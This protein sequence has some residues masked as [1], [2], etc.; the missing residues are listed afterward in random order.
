MGPSRRT[1]ASSEGRHL[2]P[3]APAPPPISHWARFKQAS[4]EPLLLTNGRWLLR[5]RAAWGGAGSGVVLHLVLGE[6][7]R[8][9]SSCRI[10]APVTK[11]AT[12]P[13]PLGPPPQGAWFSLRF[14]PRSV[15]RASSPLC[16]QGLPRFACAGL[17]ADVPG[18]L[19]RL[20]C[21]SLLGPALRGGAGTGSQRH[22]MANFHLGGFKF[23]FGQEAS[24]CMILS[25]F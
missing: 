17:V 22:H 12:R 2:P 14:P 23:R 4:L 8:G 7:G 6:A 13:G 11:E 21:R 10:P 9:C 19:L 25:G 20:K 15:A 24:W 3:R 16:F 5:R 1:R 18:F